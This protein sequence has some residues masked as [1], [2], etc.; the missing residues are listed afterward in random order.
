MN[1]LQR[2]IKARGMTMQELT[3]ALD[4]GIEMHSIHKIVSGERQT[5]YI[6]E[7]VA[8]FFGL[9]VEQ[10]FGPRSAKYLKPLIECEINRKR[11]EYAHRLKRKFL[12]D[13]TVAAR[14]RAV[15][16]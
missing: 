3:E 14:R 7:A 1:D 6:R 13:Q 8:S 2:L 16:D 10:A 5:A 9:T 11:D 12:P 15:N 4:L